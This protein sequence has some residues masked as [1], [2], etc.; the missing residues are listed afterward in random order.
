M[1]DKNDKPTIEP[2]IRQAIQALE[3]VPETGGVY[4][5]QH[6]DTQMHAVIELRELIGLGPAP[7]TTSD[8]DEVGN[9]LTAQQQCQYLDCGG[10]KCPW[11]GSTDIEGTG[12]SNSDADWHNNEIIC[13]VCGAVW[14]DIYTISGVQGVSGPIQKVTAG[15]VVEAAEANHAKGTCGGKPWEAWR[16]HGRWRVAGHGWYPAE[17]TSAIIEAIRLSRHKKKSA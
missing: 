8:D 4:D 3:N 10:G 12:E 9:L 13:N 14:L 1:N 5:Q 11:C 2:A 15:I 6:A 17:E 7:G 16:E